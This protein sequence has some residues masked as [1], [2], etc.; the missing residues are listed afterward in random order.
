MQWIPRL[1]PGK[2]I[3]ENFYAFRHY[4]ENGTIEE[5]Q[6]LLCFLQDGYYELRDSYYEYDINGYLKIMLVALCKRGT[7]ESLSFWYEDRI[8][9]EIDE[10]FEG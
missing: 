6:Q 2:A 1:R 7:A 8:K 9:T 10:Y 5:K 4:A 3:V